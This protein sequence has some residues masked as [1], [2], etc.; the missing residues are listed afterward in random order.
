M[1]AHAPGDAVD[2]GP[3]DAHGW[4]SEHGADAV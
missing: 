1:S 2:I 4:L 3:L